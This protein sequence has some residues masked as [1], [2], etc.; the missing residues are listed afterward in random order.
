MSNEINCSQYAPQVKQP[1][2]NFESTLPPNDVSARAP[3]PTTTQSAQTPSVLCLD[4]HLQLGL[5]HQFKLY[6]ITF[7]DAHSH[8]MN[9]PNYM[10]FIATPGLSH[11]QDSKK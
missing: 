7:P 8:K 1:P 4:H 9:Q 11:R 3:T 2:S 10:S 5:Q 6:S